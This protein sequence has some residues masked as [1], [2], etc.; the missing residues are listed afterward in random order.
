LEFST[1]SNPVIF[2]EIA[3]AGTSA[4]SYDEWIELYNNTDKSIFLD[5]FVMRS[6]D[7]SP[8]IDLTGSIEANGYFLIERK[9]SDE[10]DEE[11]ESPVSDVTADMWVSF[12]SG[13]SNGGEVMYLEYATSGATTTVDQ[14]DLCNNQWCG[15]SSSS[16]A[17]MERYTVYPEQYI[18]N[19]TTSVG[20]YLVYGHDTNGSEIKGTP[21]KRNSI[22][23]RFG[24][25]SISE[26]TTLTSEYSPYY[27]N[28]S[29]IIPEGITLTVDK[30]VVIKFEPTQNAKLI[31]QGS[32]Q[33]SG[34]EADPV[35]LTSIF[36]DVYGGN[37]SGDECELNDESTECSDTTIFDW[38]QVYFESTDSDSS[39][40]NA[41]VR[42][43]GQLAQS[44]STRGSIGVKDS[45]VSLDNVIVER[46]KETGVYISN[47]TSTIS[48]STF[49]NNGTEGVKI[50]SGSSNI[51]NNQFVGNEGY[52]IYVGN[53]RQSSIT[54][55]SFTGNGDDAVFSTGY[56]SDIQNN[57][58]SGNGKNSITI[59]GNLC[60][61]GKSV[62]L[63]SNSLPF[64]LFSTVTVP[65]D[66]TLTI[67]NGSVIKGN[68]PSSFKSEIVV[69]DGAT[70]ESSGGVIFT[71]AYDNSDG[72]SIF[73]E[74][75][76]LNDGD[77]LGI[78][79]KNGGTLNLSNAQ[80]KYSGGNQSS[81]NNPKGGILLENGSS[82]VLSSM[83]FSNNKVDIYKHNN[84]T[85]ECDSS[86]SG[87]L[88]DPEDLFE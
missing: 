69:E 51:S 14:V 43:G 12:G 85:I 70:L 44:V 37:Q 16:K 61:E 52:G 15:G 50:I 65:K 17:S 49:R 42:Y 32:L 1:V 41:I 25:S 75:K 26:D 82:A 66:S 74:E 62:E 34:T 4:S 80:I 35:V 83:T 60:M 73:D 78:K 10:E 58:G 30:G 23:H 5:Y 81:G 59:S 27:V 47:S 21:K 31:V 76:S 19:W 57:S 9:N 36:D 13:L 20:S 22:T 2:S 67:N 68:M 54:N 87:L 88:T 71:S 24:S 53:L 64:L 55:N 46:A 79:V 33:I 29:L 18:G 63:Q 40:S 45:T 11:T 56:I 38:G 6:A 39:I 84:A 3:W 7:E 77:W 86:C 8:Y 28:S 72:Y 48:N